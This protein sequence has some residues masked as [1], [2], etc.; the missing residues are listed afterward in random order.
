MSRILWELKLIKKSS[1]PWPRPHTEESCAWSHSDLLMEKAW[2][3]WQLIKNSQ[4]IQRTNER[5][6]ERERE[7]S[8]WPTAM[9]AT[10]LRRGYISSSRS[11]RREQRGPGHRIRRHQVIG[12]AG[13]E[14]DAVTLCTYQYIVETRLQSSAGFLLCRSPTPWTV[15]KDNWGGGTCQSSTHPCDKSI[16]PLLGGKPDSK[17]LRAVKPGV[18]WTHLTHILLCEDYL[19]SP[20]WACDVFRQFSGHVGGTNTLYDSMNLIF[21]I[22]CITLFS[23]DW[24]WLCVV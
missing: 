18:D 2:R 6:R 12:Q 9:T 4:W 14:Q 22:L 3:T 23:S 8:T 11:W 1:L 19:W 13:T 5:E 7:Q 17:L 16:W 21:H 10:S 20:M 15:Q 24:D